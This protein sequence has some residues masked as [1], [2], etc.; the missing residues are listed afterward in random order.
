MAWDQLC[1]TNLRVAAVEGWCKLGPRATGEELRVCDLVRA[2]HNLPREVDRS[3]EACETVVSDAGAVPAQVRIAALSAL[4]NLVK[5]ERVKG[6]RCLCR[7]SESLVD[8]CA[9][10]RKF[11]LQKF[12][13]ALDEVT[14]ILV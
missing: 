14:K 8:P 9:D 2:F 12:D 3:E 4:F 13:S 6:Q 10:V 7:L 1:P 5:V 11:S